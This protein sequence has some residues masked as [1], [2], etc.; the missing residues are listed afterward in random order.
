MIRYA[1]TIVLALLTT[2][3][4]AQCVSNDA[5]TDVIAVAAKSGAEAVAITEPAQVKAFMEATEY[6]GSDAADI[7]RVVVIFG[8]NKAIAFFLQEQVTCMQLT[9]ASDR[10]RGVMRAV[11]GNPA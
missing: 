7:V 4:A 1:V 5:V 10:L 9:G 11:Q 3:A 2:P 8:P 6:P